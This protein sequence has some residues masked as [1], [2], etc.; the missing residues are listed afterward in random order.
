[1]VIISFFSSH[2]SVKIIR[3]CSAYIVDKHVRNPSLT[4]HSRVS[5]NASL[6]CDTVLFLFNKEF[7]PL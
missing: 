3:N 4:R 2:L 6:I 5:S 7:M 1:M